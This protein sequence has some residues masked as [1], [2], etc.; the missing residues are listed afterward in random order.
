MEFD[1]TRKAIGAR[2]L[3]SSDRK[4]LIDK[5]T[6]AGGQVLNERARREEAAAGGSGR[7][8]DR[9]GGRGGGSDTRLP[10]QMARERQREEAER[11]AQVRRMIEAEERAASGFFARLGLK[12]RCMMAGV[13]PFGRDVAQPGFLSKLNLDAKRAIMECQILGNDL[14]LNN[15]DTAVKIV[16][17]LD[18]KNPLLAELIQRAAD[19][20]DRSELSDIVGSYSP[21]NPTAA[22]LDSI[23]APLFSLLRKLYYLK[24]FQETYMMAADAAVDAQQRIERKQAALYDAKKKRIRNEWRK[25]MNEIY[26]DLVLAAQRMEMKA[27]EPGTRLFEEMIGFDPALRPGLRKAGDPVSNKLGLQKAEAKAAEEAAQAAEEQAAEDAEAQ[28]DAADDGE[29]GGDADALSAES[30]QRDETIAAGAPADSA[31]VQPA[32]ISEDGANDDL[33]EKPA[34]KRPESDQGKEM[35]YGYRLMRILSY[36]ALRTRHDARGE[37][38][39]IP[40]RDKALIS[41]LFFKEFEEEYSFILT[42]PQIK[43]NA[44]YQSGMKI[45][46][47]QRMRDIYEESRLVED[48]F[49]KYA[50]EAAE[51]VKILKESAAPQNYVEHAKK[52][53]LLEG[54]RGVSSREARLQIKDFAGK[55]A[56][57]LKALIQDMRAANQIVANRD[58]AIRFDIDRDKKKRLNGKPI[59]DCIMQ[60]YCYSIALADRLESGDLFGGVVE[61]SEDE[62][63]SAFLPS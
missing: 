5:F 12:F 37:H 36:H 11:Q 40:D 27:A 16:K 59:K 10:S 23:R 30:A 2:N 60:A 8:G 20:Y 44:S 35:G 54:R 25:L 39:G 63:Q 48:L 47:R 45:D 52:V 32:V 46:Y 24:P 33:S 53:N 62:F 28:T 58:E 14:F 61:M 56:G 3:G 15:R 57:V 21:S 18:Q 7:G 50:H 38:K 26:P 22:P 31:M 49:R 55:V 42:T 4:E 19:L 34:A 41:Y 43:V 1:R 9:S 51:H 17:D 13:A 6:S 29:G